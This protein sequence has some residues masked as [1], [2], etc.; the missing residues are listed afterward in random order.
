MP[1][2]NTEI[3]LA[4]SAPPFA[5]LETTRTVSSPAIVP[6]A[7]DG[8]EMSATIVR[9]DAYTSL[10]DGSGIISFRSKYE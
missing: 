4:S 1:V 5:V 9:K 10:I 3:D 7:V 8:V 6:I 2:A